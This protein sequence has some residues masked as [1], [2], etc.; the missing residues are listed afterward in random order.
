MINP[1]NRPNV[2]TSIDVAAAVKWIKYNTVLALLPIVDNDRFIQL[3]RDQDGGLSGCAE[4]ID[5]NIVGEHIKLFLL[6]ALHIR[7]TGETNAEERSAVVVG[8]L[9]QEHTD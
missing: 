3:F 2:H 5:H 9:R 7:F 4:G 1:K 8:D 6:F